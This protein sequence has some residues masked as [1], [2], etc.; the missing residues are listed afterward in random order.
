MSPKRIIELAQVSLI[1]VR[2]VLSR[3]RVFDWERYSFFPGN[4]DTE[5]L[6]L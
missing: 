2:P 3:P 4:A 6:I 5:I 1:P